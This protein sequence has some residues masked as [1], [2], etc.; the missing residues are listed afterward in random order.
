MPKDIVKEIEKD[1]QKDMRSRSK[2]IAKV[3]ID[4]YTAKQ[5]KNFT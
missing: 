3:V 2:Q 5:G 1:A 4:H